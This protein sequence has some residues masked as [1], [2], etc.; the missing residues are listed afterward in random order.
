GGVALA[1]PPLGA[2]EGVW[3]GL[4]GGCVPPPP[5]LDVGAAA[6]PAITAGGA[7]ELDELLAP[8]RNAAVAAV[9]GAD[10]D[11]GFIEEFHGNLGKA[12]R[13]AGQPEPFQTFAARRVAGLPRRCASLS[14][15][16][17]SHGGWPSGVRNGLSPPV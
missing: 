13:P 15:G 11:L 9:A 6:A 4:A 8:E 14:G 7:A 3:V 2:L 17:L 10:I 5:P 1:S 16:H 12:A